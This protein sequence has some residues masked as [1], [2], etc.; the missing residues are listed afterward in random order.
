MQRLEISIWN[1]KYLVKV[2][3]N[4]ITAIPMRYIGTRM[5]FACLHTLHKRIPQYPED[6]KRVVLSTG[7]IEE[8]LSRIIF[9]RLKGAKLIKDEDVP[10]YDTDPYGNNVRRG[11]ID[12]QVWD[13][14]GV[15][16][17]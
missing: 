4:A 17:E 10:N 1:D 2:H 8:Q 6:T 12:Y 7:N 3:P 9:P 11:N 13:L 15:Y 14:S 5:E 16:E